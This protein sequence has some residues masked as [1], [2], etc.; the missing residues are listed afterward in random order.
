VLVLLGCATLL[1][2]EPSQR[3]AAAIPN[4]V[5]VGTLTTTFAPPRPLPPTD[6]L[7]L[8]YFSK[9]DDTIMRQ[10][11]ERWGYHD[12]QVPYEATQWNH[13]HLSLGSLDSP[14]EGDVRHD[15]AQSVVRVRLDTAI[16]EYFRDTEGGRAVQK[17]QHTVDQLKSVP[18]KV[19]SGS[20]PGEF[21][22]GY[23]VLSDASKI[24]YVDGPWFVGIYHPHLV[25]ALTGQ[26]AG[27]NDLSLRVTASLANPLPTASLAYQPG[28]TLVEASVSKKLSRSVTTRLISST[29]TVAGAA[30]CNYRVEISYQF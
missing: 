16:R 13:Q 26:R 7:Y 25:S 2:A 24:E 4:S 22:V 15:F 11:Q 1:Q 8:R 19:G 9:N 3:E 17:A 14:Y 20:H 6:A 30:P 10:Y 29:P 21:H 27:Q 12:M 18:V 23:D 28:S 5:P